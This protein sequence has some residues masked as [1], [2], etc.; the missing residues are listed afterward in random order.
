MWKKLNDA[1]VRQRRNGRGPRSPIGRYRHDDHAPA[2]A[3]TL[4]LIHVVA[5]GEEDGGCVARAASRDQVDDRTRW[6]G[7]VRHSSAVLRR[8]PSLTRREDGRTGRELAGC[9]GRLP[10]CRR[11][12]G[13]HSASISA[14]PRRRQD[15]RHAERRAARAGRGTDVV[16]GFV[17]THGRL[18]T[19]EQIGDLEVVPR[20]RRVPRLDSRRWTSTRCSPGPTGAR[21]RARA[22]QR[23][24][25]PQRETLQDVEELLAAG[26]DVIST[27]NI[28][29]LESINDVV[30]RITGIASGKRSPTRSCGGPTSSSSST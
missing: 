23:A 25:L 29:H 3:S 12:L 30:E 11:W 2:A 4:V 9:S 17:E 1:A 20:R 15:L 14:P 18:R 16:I 10:G 8:R 5:D 28:Q 27:V 7:V 26:I 6:P 22:Y 19:A 21:R 24:G 13:A